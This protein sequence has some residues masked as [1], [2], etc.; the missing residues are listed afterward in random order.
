M[1]NEPS[2]TRAWSSDPINA[3]AQQASALATN[4]MVLREIVT[5]GFLAAGATTRYSCDSVVAGTAG[6]GVNRWDADTDLVFA[7]AGVAHSWYVVRLPTLLGTA[8]VL[9]DLESSAT[10]SAASFWMSFV[11]FTG[12]TTTTRPTATDEFEITTSANIL[13]AVNGPK[14]WSLTW[15]TDGSAI[16]LFLREGA[17]PLLTVVMLLERVDSAPAAWVVPVVGAWNFQSAG[18]AGLIGAW[19]ASLKGRHSGATIA[20]TLVTSVDGSTNLD[21]LDL[22]FPT[23]LDNDGVNGVLG[24]MRDLYFRTTGSDKKG[25]PSGTSRRWMTFETMV[26]PWTGETFGGASANAKIYAATAYQSALLSTSPAAGALGATEEAARWQKITLKFSVPDGSKALIHG[27]MGAA[28]AAVHLVVH[29]GTDFTPL[30]KPNSTMTV[31]G[32]EHTAVIL[33][34][35]GWWAPPSLVPGA[36][37]E[38]S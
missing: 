37:E 27:W 38:A 11:G 32:T 15:A 20:C 14:E 29:D 16:R 30:F 36:F 25:Y 4:R 35:G 2:R 17:S 26:V 12:G 23:T 7:A 22:L 18:G 1:P 24:T 28:P 6:D 9:F 13:D 5:I 21:G 19:G 33:P 10:G 8:E 31:D 34:I 3:V